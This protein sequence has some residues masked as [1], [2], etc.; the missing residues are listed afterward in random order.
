[1]RESSKFIAEQPGDC[2]YA[3]CWASRHR[4]STMNL[5]FAIPNR[6]LYSVQIHFIQLCLC[7]QLHVFHYFR[8]IFNFYLCLRKISPQLMILLLRC[9]RRIS[10]FSSLSAYNNY[11]LDPIPLTTNVVFLVFF[12]CSFAEVFR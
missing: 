4:F 6:R 5:L 9:H 3:N 12:S 7:I 11:F 10:R 1:M 8:Y 2:T